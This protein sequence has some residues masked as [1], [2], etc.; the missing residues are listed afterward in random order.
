M[1]G[2]Y[3]VET[4]GAEIVYD[5]HG[6]PGADGRPPLLMIGQPMTAGGFAHAGVALPR[7]HR[8]HL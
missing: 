2:T 3:T 4:R 7:P 1:T 8:G 6:P 5:V